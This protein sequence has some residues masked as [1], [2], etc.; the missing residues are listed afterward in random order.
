MQKAPIPKFE[1]ERLCALEELNILDTAAEERF[2]KITRE[3]I[4]Y[5]KVPIFTIT[6]V[7]AE[8][9]WFKS[10]QGLKTRQGPRDISFCGHALLVQDI[11]ILEDTLD[12]PRF[13]D[14]PMVMDKPGIRFYA[15]KS[16]YHQSK[17]LPIGVFCIKDYQPR[18]M[19]MKEVDKLLTLAKEAEDEL[20]RV[21]PTAF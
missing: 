7:D 4:A 1:K 17:R 16:L 9:E 14:N 2:D 6:I 12:D 5:F 15:G 21:L 13:A 3:A 18:K 8:R 19:T 10:V 11:M 20:N